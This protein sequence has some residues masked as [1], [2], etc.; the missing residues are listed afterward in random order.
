[1]IDEKALVQAWHNA[2]NVKPTWELQKKLVEEELK[3]LLEAYLNLDPEDVDSVVHYHKEATD[4]LFVLLGLTLVE[5]PVTT[6]SDELWANRMNTLSESMFEHLNDD[7]Y[8]TVFQRVWE[9]NM[10]KLGDDGKPI[11]REDGKILKGPNYKE[12][13]LADL[14]T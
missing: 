9:S 11:F 8:E 1:M 12:P 4:L 10:S 7:V 13:Y 14:F 3:E 2:F 5:N 6:P